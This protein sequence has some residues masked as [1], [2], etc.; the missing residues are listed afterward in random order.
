[1]T[2]AAVGRRSRVWLVSIIHTARDTLEERAAPRLGLA[3]APF[4]FQACPPT[5]A[6]IE[7]LEGPP[8]AHVP[9]G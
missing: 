8:M 5:Q 6:P 2:P 7:P 1:M 4:C 3:M 9:T